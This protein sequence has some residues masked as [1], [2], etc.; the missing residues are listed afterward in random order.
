MMAS[1]C[2]HFAFV[3]MQIATMYGQDRGDC[4]EKL[5]QYRVPREG[6]QFAN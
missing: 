1:D 6:C 4:A 2:L 5:Y 3:Q